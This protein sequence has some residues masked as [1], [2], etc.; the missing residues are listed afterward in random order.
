MLKKAVAGALVAIGLNA[1]VFA[2]VAVIVHPDNTSSLTDTEIERIFLGKSAQFPDG[3]EAIPINTTG[4]IYDEFNERV[5]GRNSAQIKSYWA[6]LVFTGK[7]APPK[8]VDEAS[9]IELIKNN[10]NAIA[11]ID[12]G[13]VTDDVK[14]VLKK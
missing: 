1:S 9:V 6:K 4:D 14:V 3:S 11:Y 10:K 12:S 13:K 7:G 8:E 2:D 5:L